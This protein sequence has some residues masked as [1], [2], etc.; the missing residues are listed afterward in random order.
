MK[1]KILVTELSERPLFIANDA[2]LGWLYRV[3]WND[4][5]VITVWIGPYKTRGGA[6]AAA[7]R[8]C[9]NHLIGSIDLF[10]NR[11]NP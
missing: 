11:G 5:P 7:K 3:Q 1:T 9:P 4:K 8:H 10:Y 2:K 6:I